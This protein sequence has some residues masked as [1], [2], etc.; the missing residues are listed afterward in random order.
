M[1]VHEVALKGM[2]NQTVNRITDGLNATNSVPVIVSASPVGTIQCDLPALVAQAGPAA[3]FAWEEFILDKIRNPHTRKAYERAVRQFLRHCHSLDR[4]LS[5]VSPK[6]VGSYLDGLECAVATKKLNMSALRHFFDA[7]VTGH[8]V[9][10]N[11][12]A[13][14]RAERLQIV[15]GKPLVEATTHRH[16]VR[17]AQRSLAPV[18]LLVPSIRKDTQRP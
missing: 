16:A 18:P 10:L 6:D 7:L 17:K 5:Q 14:V 9:V 11:P 2:T 12:A 15:E 1:Y 13:S 4:E 8:V 3:Q